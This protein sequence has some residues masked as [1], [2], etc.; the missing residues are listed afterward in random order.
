MRK[1]I[2]DMWVDALRS[3]EYAQTK[4]LLRDDEGYCCLGVLCDLH[5][6]RTG[7][8]DWAGSAYR[9]DDRPEQW[10]ETVLPNPV[11]E[12][13]YVRSDPTD[14]NS[15]EFFTQLNDDKG[16]TFDQLADIIEAQWEDL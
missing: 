1:D 16:Y 4:E 3:G 14:V 11:M 12:W 5:R 6:R 7:E 10:S 13:A 2:A 8:G 9:V 15:G